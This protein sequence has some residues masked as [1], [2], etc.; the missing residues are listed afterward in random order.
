VLARELR[1]VFQ[2][3]TETAARYD[4]L[5]D[6]FVE[7]ARVALG[8]AENSLVTALLA[9]DPTTFLPFL[10]TDAAPLLALGR[11]LLV[12]QA[13]ALGADIDAQT[14][15][16]FAELAAR[17]GVSFLLTRQTV[18]PVD[19]PDAARRSLRRVFGPLLAPM[20]VPA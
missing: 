4:T 14:A 5:L 18:F 20:S 17:L 11:Q 3:V 7:G 8:A 12:A 16:E 1:Q 2:A 15:S 13:M 19:D 6:K 9:S 10:T